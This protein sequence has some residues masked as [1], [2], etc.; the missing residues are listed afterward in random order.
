M[1]E[2]AK[3]DGKGLLGRAASAKPWKWEPV[4]F[5]VE[6]QA[7]VKAED[8]WEGGMAGM[9]TEMGRNQSGKAFVSCW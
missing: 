8:E 3:K 5:R 4:W 2:L 7:A 1:L 9:T 6:W